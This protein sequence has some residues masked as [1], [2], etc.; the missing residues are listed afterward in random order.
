ME[1]FNFHIAAA[2]A[3]GEKVGADALR[4]FSSQ[5]HG[6]YEAAVTVSAKNEELR[7]TVARLEAEIEVLK[8]ALMSAEKE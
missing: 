8:S 4:V 6:F 5:A 3:R 7:R 1:R 2:L